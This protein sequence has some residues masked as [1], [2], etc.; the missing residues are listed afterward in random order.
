LT[1]PFQHRWIRFTRWPG[2]AVDGESL[3]QNGLV[4]VRSKVGGAEVVGAVV[5]GGVDVIG[6]VL[7][8]DDGIVAGREVENGDALVVAGGAVA[9]ASAAKADG[10]RSVAAAIGIAIVSGSLILVISSPHPRCAGET[11]TRTGELPPMRD[12]YRHRV[13][14]VSYGPDHVWARW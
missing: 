2:V 9:G 12:S 10:A 6:A 3:N 4:G 7:V 11:P 1:G 5:V 14:P 8:V 13:G